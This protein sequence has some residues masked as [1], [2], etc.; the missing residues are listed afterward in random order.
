MM[1]TNPSQWTT[2]PDTDL[3]EPLSVVLSNPRRHHVLTALAARP[4][5][6]S[7][8]DDLAV[9]VTAFERAGGGDGDPGDSSSEVAVTLHHCHLPK[10]AQAGVVEDGYDEGEVA[11]TERGVECA[12]ALGVDRFDR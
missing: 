11:L 9:A 7:S 3:A 1:S 10:L 8:F 6:A 5:R 4:D 2:R 12:A